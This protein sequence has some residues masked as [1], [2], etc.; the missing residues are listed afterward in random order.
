[1]TGISGAQLN[2]QVQD[3]YAQLEGLKNRLA[4][5]ATETYERQVRERIVTLLLSKDDFVRIPDCATAEA[6]AYVRYIVDGPEAK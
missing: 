4:A 6:E 5:R 3:L 1:M 2:A